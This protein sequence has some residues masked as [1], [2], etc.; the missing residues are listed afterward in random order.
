MMGREPEE[1]IAEA[2]EIDRIINQQYR[3]EL[4]EKILHPIRYWK[5]H[6]N[7]PFWEKYKNIGVKM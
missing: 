7:D 1:I 5:K 6:K 4:K 3:E 2:E